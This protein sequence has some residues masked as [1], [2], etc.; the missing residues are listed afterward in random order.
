MVAHA[1]KAVMRLQSERR[2]PPHDPLDIAVMLLSGADL[3][4]ADSV[5]TGSTSDGTAMV[6]GAKVS[7]DVSVRQ[8]WRC[9]YFRIR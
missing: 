9:Y 5:S 6:P 4:M 7:D 1:I 8:L 3:L 2:H